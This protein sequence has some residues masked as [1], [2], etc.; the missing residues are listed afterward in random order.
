[1]LPDWLKRVL[2]E[3]VTLGKIQ[4]SIVTEGKSWYA[5]AFTQTVK[6]VCRSCNTGWM[7]RLEDEAKPYLSPLIRGDNLSPGQAAILSVEAQTVIARWA[8]KTALVIRELSS[9]VDIPVPAAFYRQLQANHPLDPIPP[10]TRIRLALHGEFDRANQTV[11]LKNPVFLNV[12]TGELVP[13]S[14][15]IHQRPDEASVSFC[16]TM[17]IGFLIVQVVAV[18][19][20]GPM[21]KFEVGQRPG[22]TMQVWPCF[23]QHRWPPS[24][25]FGDDELEKLSVEVLI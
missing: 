7:S 12:F 9:G 3:V 10:W 21:T 18:Y 2:P 1:M 8:L 13:R 22:V 4:H 24:Y 17:A 25:P 23:G 15:Q 14:S 16:V 6:A 11:A 5:R 20:P 19:E